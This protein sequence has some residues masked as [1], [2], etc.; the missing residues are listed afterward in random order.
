M[1]ELLMVKE[2]MQ[3]TNVPYRGG[4]PALADLV[5]GQVRPS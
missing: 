2:H 5:A 1:M 3:V 4:A